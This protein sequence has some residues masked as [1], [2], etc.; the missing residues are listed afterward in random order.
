MTHVRSVRR[1]TSVRVWVLT[2]LSCCAASQAAAS[3]FTFPLPAG[4]QGLQCLRA[5]SH[6]A[7]L[8]ED[9]TE[10]VVAGDGVLFVARGP[11]GVSVITPEGRELATLKMDARGLSLDGSQLWVRGDGL[12]LALVDVTEPAAPRLVGTY[13][14]DPTFAFGFIQAIAVRGGLLWVA[15]SG[16]ALEL[17]D[18]S[19]WNRAT[20]LWRQNLA[21]EVHSLRFQENLLLAEHLG[22]TTSVWNVSDAAHPVALGPALEGTVLVDGPT[23]YLAGAGQLSQLELHP[24]SP[25]TL[26]PLAALGPRDFVVAIADGRVFLRHDS[27]A[28]SV[29]ELPSLSFVAGVMGNFETGSRPVVRSG[30]ALF[31]ASRFGGLQRLQ[32]D[33]VTREPTERRFA[34]LSLERNRFHG[35]LFI[36]TLEERDS[37][38]RLL[39]RHRLDEPSLDWDHR[40][41]P[42]RRANASSHPDLSKLRVG[43]RLV[44]PIPRTLLCRP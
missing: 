41:E 26:R 15:R 33:E 1:P 10:D 35:D 14:E 38:A 7:V 36:V 21:A 20:L 30:S 40:M 43:A 28:L 44:V 18:V 37:I 29:L 11:Y 8:V 3:D 32:L 23:S 12:R 24:D 34:G 25:P 16:G 13:A 31:F 22:Q 5:R 9:L 2:L 17:Y 27:V 6:T 42:L 19:T 4:A 39:R